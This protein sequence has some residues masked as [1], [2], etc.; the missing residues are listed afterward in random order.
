MVILCIFLS[1]ACYFDYCRHKIPNWLTALLLAI[2]FVYHLAEGG[3]SSVA[4]LLLCV[5]V[6]ILIFYPLFKIGCLGAGDIKLFGACVGFLPTGKIIWFLFFSFF[7]AAVLSIIKIL[8]QRD[9]VER[10]RY[11]IQYL[12]DVS[13]SGKWKLYTDN[14]NEKTSGICFAGPVFA[15]VLLY[16]GGAY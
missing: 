2:S 9:A 3:I 15:S 11:T 6:T 14:K 8:R 1:I 5:L 13:I 4:L 10:F 7:F 16:I 12:V